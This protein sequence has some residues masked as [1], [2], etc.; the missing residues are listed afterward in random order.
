MQLLAKKPE[1]GQYQFDRELPQ[2]VRKGERVRRP[3]ATPA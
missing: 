3:D 2:T 1:T